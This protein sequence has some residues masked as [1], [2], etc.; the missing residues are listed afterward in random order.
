MDKGGAIYTLP[1]DGFDPAPQVGTDVWVNK[2]PVIPINKEIVPSALKAM[3]GAGVQ[4]YFVSE[5]TFERFR[6][7]PEERQEILKSFVS[8]NLKQENH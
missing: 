5:D 7:L 2:N 4:V 8:E 6:D 1:P 3:I